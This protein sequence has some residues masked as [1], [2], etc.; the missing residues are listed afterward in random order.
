MKKVPVLVIGFNRP[1]LLTK[2]LIRLKELGISDLYVSLDGYR[3]SK[4]LLFLEGE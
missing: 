4:D 3:N 2:L 1:D